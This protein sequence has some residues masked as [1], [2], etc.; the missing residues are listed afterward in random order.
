MTNIVNIILNVAKLKSFVLKTGIRQGCL[1]LFN[2]VLKSLATALK[3]EKNKR[4]SNMKG[5]NQ[6]ILFAD[7]EISMK[8]YS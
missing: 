2:I 6:I 7:D 8:K 4:N 3:Q 5:G 1:L